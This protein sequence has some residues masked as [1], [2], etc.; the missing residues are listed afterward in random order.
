MKERSEPNLQ[1]SHSKRKLGN[2]DLAKGRSRFMLEREIL[3]TQVGTL[4]VVPGNTCV[5]VTFSLKGI[6]CNLIIVPSF[7][8]LYFLN[9]CPSL[10]FFLLLPPLPYSFHKHLSRVSFVPVLQEVDYSM[11]SLNSSLNR[12]P[13]VLVI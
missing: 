4:G 1:L 8:F 3:W 13:R 5:T 11:E 2:V 6:W 7:L 10:S 9:L 12:C